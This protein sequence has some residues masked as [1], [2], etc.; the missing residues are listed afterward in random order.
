M[1]AAL[2]GNSASL[3]TLKL[4]KDLPRAAGMAAVPPS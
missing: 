4:K 3:E 2:S 1:A